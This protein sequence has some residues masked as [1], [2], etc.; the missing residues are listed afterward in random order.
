MKHDPLNPTEAFLRTIDVHQLL[1]QQE[2][3]VMIGQLVHLDKVRTIAQFEVKKDCLLVDNDRLSAAGLIENIAQTCAARIGYVNKYIMKKDVQIG[4]IG[5]IRNFEV[6]DLPH[7]GDTI[8]TIVDVLED[9]FG[10]TLAVATIECNGKTL[11]T[12]E[13]KLAVKNGDEE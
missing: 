9:V 8:T 5:A 7:V 3:F 10:M 2:P 11:A 13:I 6:M 1:P 12:T 4:F